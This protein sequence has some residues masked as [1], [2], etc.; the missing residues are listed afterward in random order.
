[1][2]TNLFKNF[3]FN[4]CEKNLTF[5]AVEIYFPPTDKAGSLKKSFFLSQQ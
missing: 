3:I 1:M 2:E 4:Q 5:D